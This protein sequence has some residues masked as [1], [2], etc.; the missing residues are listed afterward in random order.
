MSLIYYWLG[1]F[2]DREISI[3]FDKENEENFS[4]RIADNLKNS[5]TCIFSAK[6]IKSKEIMDSNLIM[7]F[8]EDENL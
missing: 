2:S 6:F 3:C 8:T 5:E 1:P 7:K 4:R